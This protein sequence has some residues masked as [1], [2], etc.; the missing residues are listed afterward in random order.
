MLARRDLTAADGRDS[1]QNDM[2][3]IWAVKPRASDPI[4]FNH[5]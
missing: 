5:L 2:R 4:G 3:T 1:V